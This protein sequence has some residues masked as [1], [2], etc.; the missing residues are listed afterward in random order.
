MC[1]SIILQAKFFWI[2]LVFNWEF[3]KY[4]S[5][6]C[7]MFTCLL[8]VDGQHVGVSVTEGSTAYVEQIFLFLVTSDEEH[9]N[10]KL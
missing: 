10:S 4:N 5:N 9:Q 3:E 6:V 2:F 8:V 7:Q 1:L